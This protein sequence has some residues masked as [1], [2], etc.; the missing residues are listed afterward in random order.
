LPHPNILKSF[1]GFVGLTGYHCKF[2]KNYEKIAT[3]L[4]ALLK[5]N[6]FTWTPVVAQDFQSLKMAM[7]TTPVLA[8]PDFTKTF[9]LECDAS[10]KGIGVVLMQEGRPLAFTSK[11]LSERNMGKSIYEKEM[12]A[13]LH[14]VD[15]WRPYLLGQRFQIKTNHQ[16]LKYFLE[17]RISSPEQQKW[18]I[19]LFGYDYE[20]IYKKGID[21]VVADALSRKYEDEGSL[22]SLS[23]IVPDWLQAIRQ[24]WLQ[25]PKS[26]QLIQ[27]LQ[28][29]A[30]ASLGYS[31]LHEEF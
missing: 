18:V 10:G 26:S 25:D 3:P 23:F 22:F 21:N 7:F 27:Q 16:S 12:L 8:L 13:I 1:Y 17:Q 14:V 2:V 31:W 20:I 4:T 24:E 19:K 9:V 28:S 6:S 15:L 5:K 11:Q 30:P 29:N